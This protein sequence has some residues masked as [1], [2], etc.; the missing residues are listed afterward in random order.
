MSVFL[1]FFL[2]NLNIGY[3]Q[4]QLSFSYETIDKVRFL[5][6]IRRMDHLW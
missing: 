4:T 6:G 1:Q 5:L 3:S 2:S